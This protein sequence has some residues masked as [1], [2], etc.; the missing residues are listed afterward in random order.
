[1]TNPAAGFV[2]FLYLGCQG[3]R[4]GLTRVHYLVHR[5]TLWRMYCCLH[6][7]GGSVPSSYLSR[8]FFPRAFVGLS[9]S[10][11]PFSTDVFGSSS[12]S[13]CEHLW[14]VSF[15]ICLH[16]PP[17]CQQSS[18]PCVL[19]RS[20]FRALDELAPCLLVLWSWLCPWHLWC[21]TSTLEL[22]GLSKICSRTPSLRNDTAAC[23]ETWKL[24]FLSSSS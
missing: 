14:A 18:Y 7:S 19:P 6:S 15:A 1:M 13:L 11:H 23:A 12:F 22:I 4:V 10:G 21:N 17:T 20:L 24:F 3:R 16:F 9:S 5:V 8:S 2:P